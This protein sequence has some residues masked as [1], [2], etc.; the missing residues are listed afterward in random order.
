M[1]VFGVSCGKVMII[2][3]GGVGINVV[4]IVIGFGVDVIII[5]LS[6]ECLC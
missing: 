6:F 4:K 5:D 1:G 3:G 2:G